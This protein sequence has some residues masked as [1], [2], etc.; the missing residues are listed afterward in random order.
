MIQT[1][2]FGGQVPE[3]RPTHRINA[4]EICRAA[5]HE[6]AKTHNGVMKLVAGAFMIRPEGATADQVAASLGCVLNTARRAVHYLAAEGTLLAMGIGN[7]A[8]KNP[9]VLYCHKTHAWQH[10]AAIAQHKQAAAQP[11]GR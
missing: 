5:S 8:Y 11:E 4:A 10:A 7:S 9:Q 3:L 1:D 2:L 6:K